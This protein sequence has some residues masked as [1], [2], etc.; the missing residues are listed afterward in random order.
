MEVYY[1][2]FNL[3]II[4]KLICACGLPMTQDKKWD[5][6]PGAGRIL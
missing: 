4:P 3:D 5:T 2:G 6:V 1:L